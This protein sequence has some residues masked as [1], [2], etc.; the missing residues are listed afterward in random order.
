MD[1]YRLYEG[2]KRKKDQKPNIV[3]VG[4]SGAGKTTIGK[5]L[6]QRLGFGF[7]DT[8]QWIC[9]EAKL[10]V[11]EVFR[12]EGEDGFRRREKEAISQLE[13]IRNHVIAVGGGAVLD[14]ENWQ[15]LSNLAETV[16]VNAPVSVIA[17]RILADQDQLRSRPLL[18]DSYVD[19]D[20]DES[21]ERLVERLDSLLRVREGLY[22]KADYTLGGGFSTPENCA[23]Q[24]LGMMLQ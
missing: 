21:F 6:A 22:A 8:D 1:L 20:S 4:L 16:W 3:L 2:V 11:S 17:R 10:A 23:R 15:I 5:Q 14:E 12:K 24:L 7:L 18:V 19:Q 13:F 9:D